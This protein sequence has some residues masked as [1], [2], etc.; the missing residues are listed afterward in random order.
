MFDQNGLTNFDTVKDYDG[1]FNV[2]NKQIQDKYNNKKIKRAIVF[3]PYGNKE[4]ETNYLNQYKQKF[5]SI[6]YDLVNFPTVVV[7][8]TGLKHVAIYVQLQ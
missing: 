2:L 8:H 6:P 7:S 5:G 1:L 4:I 3:V